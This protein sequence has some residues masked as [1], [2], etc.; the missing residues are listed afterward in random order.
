MVFW[1]WLW[2]CVSTESLLFAASAFLFCIYCGKDV[3]GALL[4]PVP[5]AAVHGSRCPEYLTRSALGSSNCWSST[6][7]EKRHL[8]H[9][10]IQ[11]I[12]GTCSQGALWTWFPK[13]SVTAVCSKDA[14]CRHR[15]CWCFQKIFTHRTILIKRSLVMWLWCPSSM[16]T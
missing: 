10:P 16:F 14:F 1:E 4:F 12:K 9:F 7:T 5:R 8:C 11:G 13:P 3:L 15:L 6:F 2:D